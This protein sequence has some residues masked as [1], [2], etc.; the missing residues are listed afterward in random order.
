[1]ERV[2][3][4]GREGGGREGGREGGRGGE[5]VCG[6]FRVGQTLSGRGGCTHQSSFGFRV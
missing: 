3:F 5:S 1:M 2:M 6:A 4:M